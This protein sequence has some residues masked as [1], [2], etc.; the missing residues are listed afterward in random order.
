M[1]SII[2]FLRMASNK[3]SVNRTVTFVDPPST[4]HYVSVPVPA[5]SLNEEIMDTAFV[6]AT[7]PGSYPGGLTALMDAHR[8]GDSV[9]LGKHWSYKYLID[10]D[11]MGYSGRFMSFLASDSVPLKA[12]VYEEFFSD[13]I[14]PW[15][16]LLR[17]FRYIPFPHN[18]HSPLQG[19]FH[20][21]FINL[22]RNL[23]YP[24]ILLWRN[25]CGASS[26]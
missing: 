1:T 16:V 12:T 10:L 5:A 20:P 26:R 19:S 17:S 15:C 14:Q 24:R 2:R 9:P 7:S 8:F 23:Q 22:S 6:K 4:T 25:N 18:S 21:S 3:S 11:G 13:W